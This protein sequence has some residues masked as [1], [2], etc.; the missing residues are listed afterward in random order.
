MNLWVVGTVLI[1]L[2][3]VFSLLWVKYSPS[4]VVHHI[5]GEA[6]NGAV[7][8]IRNGQVILEK[9][10]DV[11]MPLA[12]T[13]K[14]I[15]L[16]TFARQAA[17]NKV[18]PLENIPLSDLEKYYIPNTDGGAHQAWLK[19]VKSKGLPTERETVSLLEVVKG[20]M[21]F[22]SN[23]NTEYLFGKLGLVSIN[24]TLHVLNLKHH[25]KLYP[26]NSALLVLRDHSMEELL[27]MG[28][29]NYIK[30]SYEMYVKLTNKK[31]ARLIS[32]RS[33]TAEKQRLFSRWLVRGTTREYA[34]LLGM[35]SDESY[36]SDKERMYIRQAMK[37]FSS[38]SEF[39]FSGE[40]E[41]V[42]LFLYAV[43]VCAV[44]RSGDKVELALFLNNLTIMQY[45]L[46]T[47][48]VAR[49]KSDLLNNRN[50]DRYEKILRSR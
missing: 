5:A 2:G 21:Q 8:L 23:A 14:M 37:P 12:S 47:F 25:E 16:I 9:H 27:C 20:M 10:A 42:S 24:N 44:F 1:G 40:K 18:D 6:G 39:V 30:L 3:G 4:R 36:F 49:L 34:Y 41:G 50:I 35:I 33:M 15:V 7:C 43:V 28:K 46:Y 45:F 17:D 19:S 13:V 26:F 31:V 32:S 22:S 48:S 29:E 11:A 38:S